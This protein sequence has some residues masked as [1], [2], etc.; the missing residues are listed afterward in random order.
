MATPTQLFQLLASR[1]PR[2]KVYL[3]DPAFPFRMMRYAV[4]VALYFPRFLF[5]RIRKQPILAFDCRLR[6]YDSFYE[7]IYKAWLAQAENR[8]V[9]VFLFR[10]ESNHRRPLPLWRK[11]L[12]VAYADYLD[13]KVCIAADAFPH[14]ALPRTRR[15]QIFHGFGSF[16]ASKPVETYVK[17]Y[18]VFFM[19][20]YFLKEQ[21]DSGDIKGTEGK[22]AYAVGYPKLDPVMEG[23]RCAKLPP[24]GT[25]LFYGPT[26]SPTTSSLFEFLPELVE[27][28]KRRRY[29]LLL[30]LHPYLYHKRVAS[31]SGGVDWR[32]RIREYRA[33]HAP[34]T[35][36]GERISMESL[37]R[38]F[39]ETDLFITDS[40]GLGFEFVLT[41]GKPILFL[42][43]KVKVPR[44]DVRG[45]D[46]YP[47]IRYRGGIGPIIVSPEE[48]E[49]TVTQLLSGNP[50][51]AAIAAFRE[52]FVP[53]PGAAA[54]Q[55]VERIEPLFA[56]L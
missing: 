56:Q 21:F 52:D 35:L 46:Q 5:L 20:T 2:A 15:V 39:A 19:P 53:N 49:Q 16:G 47:E 43:N 10:F 9:V 37:G 28:C 31:H 14:K 33:Q 55:A 54:P 26:Y 1:Y 13:R 48:L 27:L 11:G 8:A 40:S 36:I 18:D 50:Y 25:T 44:Q 22:K 42:G 6:Q 24:S 3:S 30:K 23:F 45:L 41:T 29:R 7:P 51:Q 17:P 4:L 34:I 12:P 32:G 38:L